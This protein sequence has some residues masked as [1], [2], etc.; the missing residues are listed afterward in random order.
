MGYSIFSETMVE[1]PWTEIEKAAG[2]DSIVLLPVG[3]IEEHGP[4]MGLAVDTYTA[5]LMSVLT[6]R[7]LEADGIQ[8]LIAPPQYWGISE[9]TATFGGTFSVRKETMKSLVYDILA[10]LHRWGLN[11]VFVIN[12][13]ADYR[14]CKTILEAAGEARDGTGIDVRCLIS[15]SDIVRFRLTGDEDYILVQQS[16][17]SMGEPSEYVDYHAGSLE[18]GFMAQYY[19][20]DVDLTTASG[21]P[22]SRVTDE[23]LRALGGSE[24]EIRQTIPQGYFGNPAAYDADR[25]RQFTEDYA[26]DLANTISDFLKDG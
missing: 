15:A 10:S 6:K 11:R 18:T 22:D 21:L 9:G 14:H 16:P 13:H 23:D 2:Q 4:H 19:P 7:N 20:D 1:M 17:P 5:Y 25:A 12:W 3:I 8:T 26:R 24:E